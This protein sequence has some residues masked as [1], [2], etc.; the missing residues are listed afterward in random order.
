M[1][2]ELATRIE[3]M[4][5]FLSQPAMVKKL[6]G[7]IP[8]HMDPQRLVRLVLVAMSRSPKLLECTPASVARSLMDAASLGLD[9]SGTLGQGYMVPYRNNK[10]NTTEALFIPGYRG[11]V[12]LAR[13]SGAV[14]TVRARVVYAKDRFSVVQGT[15]EKIEHIPALTD[16]RGELVAVYAIAVLPDGTTQHDVMI[17]SEIA[18]IKAR[19]KAKDYG[20]WV[21]DYAEMARKTVVRRLCKY[22]PLSVDDKLGRA[23]A[24]DDAIDNE[25]AGMTDVDL[26]N[27][28]EVGTLDEGELKVED[29]KP[30]DQPNR[31][32]G[33]EDP[34][35][36]GL[37]IPPD[38]APVKPQ[39][40][41]GLLTLCEKSDGAKLD[42][43]GPVYTVRFIPPSKD[44]APTQLVVSD[45]D[46]TDFSVKTWD[47][48][49]WLQP[50]V[51][52]MLL[53]VAVEKYRDK[54]TYKVS[55][56]RLVEDK[57]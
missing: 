20:P 44:K 4:R 28:R 35:P 45:S 39:G 32:H 43:V 27:L 34:E 57:P 47:T 51:N 56:I 1:A 33:N 54:L 37:E 26:S 21:T 14:T 10:N 31:G 41:V 3:T 36:P 29:L 11:L 23:L 53:G 22:L 46:V 49:D 25:A 12:T 13:Q 2:N 9:A 19:S 30:S 42:S 52:I 5:G 24:H 38:P 40:A 50:G 55:K 48:P 7:V 15:D 6:Q 18:G 16:D 8:Q 17:A